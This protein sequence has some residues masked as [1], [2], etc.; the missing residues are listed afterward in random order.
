M[1]CGMC[2][3]RTGLSLSI[4]FPGPPRYLRA[5]A[6]L[7]VGM[8]TRAWAHPQDQGTAFGRSGCSGNSPEMYRT[9]VK[10]TLECLCPARG[11]E[12]IREGN[13]SRFVSLALGSETQNR[14]PKPSGCY[15]QCSSFI[16]QDH[17]DPEDVLHAR[18]T[19][20]SVPPWLV[21][22]DAS[23]CWVCW[24]SSIPTH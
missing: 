2:Q 5:W 24:W 18:S 16:P 4:P 1:L 11:C 19:L 10:G 3:C 15:H 17:G 22:P 9:E 8:V 7:A 20:V 23:L 6:A 13:I 12:A 14:A 21:P